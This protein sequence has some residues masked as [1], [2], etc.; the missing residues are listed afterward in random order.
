MATIAIQLFSILNYKT[1][2][3]FVPFVHLPSILPALPE[4][5]GHLPFMAVDYR[6]RYKLLIVTVFTM[7]FINISLSYCKFGKSFL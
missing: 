4:G 5:H 7:N 3:V 2:D 6:F 1:S